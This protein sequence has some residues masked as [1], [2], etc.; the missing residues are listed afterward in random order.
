MVFR[1][2]TRNTASVHGPKEADAMGSEANKEVA[3]R[4]YEGVLNQ[5]DLDAL[6]E[7]A[8]PDYEEHDPLPGQGS[9]IKGLQD[10]VR[11]IRDAFGQRFTI[12]DVVAE[13]DRVVVRW[14]GSGTHVGEFIGIPPT[15]KSFTITGLDIHR[16]V[17]GRMAEHWHVVD[18]FALLQQLG[19]IPQPDEATA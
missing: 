3:R 10:R 1:L 2:G 12:E 4:Y 16:F 15:G 8:V 19:L 17:D 9:G 7:M 13:E 14:T 18:Q 11:M 5:G 6:A